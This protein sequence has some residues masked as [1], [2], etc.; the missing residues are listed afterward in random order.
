MYKIMKIRHYSRRHL[1][2][3]KRRL[4]EIIKQSHKNLQDSNYASSY[5]L[6]AES[7]PHARDFNLE[8]AKDVRNRVAKAKEKIQ[9]HKDWIEKKSPGFFRR[10]AFV[11]KYVVTWDLDLPAVC[12]PLQMRDLPRKS[13]T[14][15]TNQERQQSLAKRKS[16]MQDWYCFFFGTSHLG[17]PFLEEL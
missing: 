16:L 1:P 8:F 7:V 5:E 4:Q 14:R 2:E 3:T 12:Y 13:R 9:E 10:M 11:Q 17:N 15:L 6:L